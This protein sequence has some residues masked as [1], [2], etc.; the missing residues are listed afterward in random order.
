M[1]CL[2]IA[3]G[4]ETATIKAPDLRILGVPG[5]PFFTSFTNEGSCA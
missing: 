5:E 4:L 1:A 2:G 3:L